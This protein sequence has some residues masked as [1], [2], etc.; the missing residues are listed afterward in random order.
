M[1]QW[2]K[3]NLGWDDPPCDFAS[4]STRMVDMWESGQGNCMFI[5]KNN[6]KK[7]DGTWE[8]HSGTGCFCSASAVTSV[9]SSCSGLFRSPGSKLGPSHVDN[10]YINRQGVS[11]FEV[12]DVDHGFAPK[13]AICNLLEV[14]RR[15]V[16]SVE[17]D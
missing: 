9:E 14:A 5:N 1:N 4:F 15:A 12:C 13:R 16:P 10:S 11:C 17:V 8:K 6:G 2:T 7:M 3:Q